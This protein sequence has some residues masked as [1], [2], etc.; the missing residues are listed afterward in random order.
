MESIIR[1]NDSDKFDLQTKSQCYRTIK[2]CT[3]LLVTIL[4]CICQQS[5][6]TSNLNMISKFGSIFC[7]LLAVVRHR[8]AFSAVSINFEEFIRIL[9]SSNNEDV[10]IQVK[11]WLMGFL[12][13][14]ST[15]GTS[16]TRRSAGFPAAI[17]A[18]VGTTQYGRDNL[19]PNTMKILF[20][21]VKQPFSQSSSDNVDLPQV[22]ALNVI[23]AIINYTD[24][25]YGIKQFIEQSLCICFD[26][27]SSV[28]FPI[29]NSATML[30]TVLILKG[31]KSK[32]SKSG[33]HLSG[34]TGREFF[35]SYPKL[36]DIVLDYLRISVS[37]LKN[38]CSLFTYHKGEIHPTLF[39]IL[40]LISK[41]MF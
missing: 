19:L 34:V 25:V 15:G 32:E 39:P 17:Y 26:G 28:Y 35:L 7:D 38:V 10:H 40:T 3:G 30:F 29:R 6:L 21:I 31:L 5:D 8:G 9:L 4:K 36:H 13:H 22:H 16:Y 37:G 33:T 23:R 24:S 1:S 41:C 14:I 12:R 18:I 2:E 11:E 20:G 27:F